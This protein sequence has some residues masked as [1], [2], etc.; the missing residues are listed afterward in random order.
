MDVNSQIRLGTVLSS[1][2]KESSEYSGPRARLKTSQCCS[3]L[4]KYPVRYS[5]LKLLNRTQASVASACDECHA[6]WR[7]GKTLVFRSHRDFGESRGLRLR[8]FVKCTDK[9]RLS[10]PFKAALNRFLLSIPNYGRAGTASSWGRRC[11]LDKCTN[12]AGSVVYV[13]IH[14]GGRVPKVLFD[15]EVRERRKAAMLGKKCPSLK[16]WEDMS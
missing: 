1:A 13:P 7:Q 6:V 10:T 5:E 2:S 16:V 3:L 8:A 4:P 15:R 9:T 12:C 14:L 11:Y